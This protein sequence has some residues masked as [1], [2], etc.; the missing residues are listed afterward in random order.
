MN[1]PQRDRT[2]RFERLPLWAIN[3]IEQLERYATDLEASYL[4]AIKEGPEDSVVFNVS[5][6]IGKAKI[7]VGVL[8]DSFEFVTKLI[9]FNVKIY[10]DHLEILDFKFNDTRHRSIAIRPRV[11]NSIEVWHV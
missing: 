10:E 3:Y 9:R 6:P 5:Q 4:L 2:R 11:S 7:P 1:I 8:G